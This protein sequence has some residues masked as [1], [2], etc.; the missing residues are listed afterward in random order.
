MSER[1]TGDRSGAELPPGWTAGDAST[2]GGHLYA[3]VWR[4]FHDATPFEHGYAMASP[5]SEPG[6]LGPPWGD[7]AVARVRALREAQGGRSDL[8]EGVWQRCVLLVY[9]TLS[10]QERQNPEEILTAIAVLRPPRGDDAV[11]HASLAR[12]GPGRPPWTEVAF[13]EH[14]REAESRAAPSGRLADI[15]TGFRSLDGTSGV[16][17]DYLRRLRG[18]FTRPTEIPE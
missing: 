8:P 6:G 13:L 4:V 9:P 1:S 12:R 16:D 17:P 3:A 7:D 18:R 10:E 14:W 5:G 15:A 2:T 11:A